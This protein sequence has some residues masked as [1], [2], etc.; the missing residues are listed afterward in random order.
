MA[1]IAT[2]ITVGG[3]FLSSR[4]AS[5]NADAQNAQAAEQYAIDKQYHGMLQGYQSELESFSAHQLAFSREQQAYANRSYQIAV[6]NRNAE[7]AY[8]EEQ[9]RNQKLAAQTEYNAQGHV[10]KIRQEGAEAQAE[11]VINDA[12]RVAG[13]DRRE[14][15][16]QA[17][18]MMGVAV[19]K[20]R[21]GLAQGRS[22]DRIVVDAFIQ[23]NKAL[24]DINSK[25]RAS[26]IQTIQAKDKINN[27]ANIKL[28][29][30]YRGLE[31]IMKMKPAPVAQVA[32]P[33]PVFDYVAPLQPLAPLGASPASVSGPSF[34]E[35]GLNAASGLNF[36]S[37]GAVT[38]NSMNNLTP[39]PMGNLNSNDMY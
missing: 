20:H 21:S 3:K 29:E 35:T 22:K 7:V 5:S 11:A 18:K 4:R 32:P 28:A 17:D 34:L 12:L 9:V 25:A 16:V 31:A 13:A 23:R 2:A 37:L 27:D 26:I 10:A 38:S 14:L 36:G 1:W 24:G 30:S 39:T 33:M 8:R 19:A 6:E 15:T